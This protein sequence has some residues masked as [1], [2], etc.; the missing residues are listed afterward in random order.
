[1]DSQT[2]RL[3][4]KLNIAEKRAEGSFRDLLSLEEKYNKLYRITERLAKIIEHKRLPGSETECV[5][6]CYR[7]MV[8]KVLKESK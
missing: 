8:D 2:E 7:C 6:D 3:I 5:L 1:M 4:R